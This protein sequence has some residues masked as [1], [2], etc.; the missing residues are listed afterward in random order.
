MTASSRPTAS[1]VRDWPLA[2]AVA[3]VPLTELLDEAWACPLRG[4]RT[5]PPTFFL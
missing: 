2:D 5:A 1:A 4:R 3:H